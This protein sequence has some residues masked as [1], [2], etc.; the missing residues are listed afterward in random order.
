MNT[1]CRQ[2]GI[3]QVAYFVTDI[4]AAARRANT[5]FGTGPFCLYENIPL[6]D[7]EYRGQAAVLDHSSAYGQSGNVM[8]EFAQ[9]NNEGPSAFR[10]MYAEGE[11]G[12][13]HVAMFV[14]DIGR[15]IEKYR[16]Q[17]YELANHYFAGGVEVAF[18]DTHKELGHMLEL[19][20]P[21]KG[22]EKFYAMVAA[23]SAK[24]DGNELFYSIG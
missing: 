5:L 20:E 1:A 10:D 17:G 12:L 15:E 14:D 3:V 11:E 23:K 7:V 4:R 9:Q 22:L 8:I 24:W 13:H 16:D 18:I 2:G 6:Q 21:V 19:Y